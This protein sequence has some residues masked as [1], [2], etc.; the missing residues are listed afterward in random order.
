MKRRTF[1]RNSTAAGLALGM[2]VFPNFLSPL[3]EQRF[4]VAEAGYYMRWY[5]D[6]KSEVYPPFANALDMID[7]CHS[8][9]FGGVQ[10]NVRDWDK[11]MVRAVRDRQDS[12]GMFVEGQVRLPREES[13]LARFE[14]EITTARD[15]GV[16]I[17]RSVCLSGRRY[18]T[19][20]SLEAFNTFREESIA[21]IRR[22]E[23]V[24]RKQRVKLALENHKDW[25]F[26][27]MIEVLKQI[28]SEWV[29]VTLD[30]GNNIALL[31][32]PM[33]VV[34]ALAP[35][36]FSVHLKDM[37]VEEYADGFLLS[38][39]NLGEGYLD[40]PEMIRIIREHNAEARFNL[41]MITRDPL[42]IPCL[43][44]AYWATFAPRPAREL[45]AY[46]HS[47]RQ[48]KRQP[49]TLARIS[50]QPTDVQLALEVENNRSCLLHAKKQ[51]GFM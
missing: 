15:A 11:G 2:P 19:F 34:T 22:A 13:D 23:P 33:E 50:G 20:D 7:H 1:V 45:A 9:G 8:L 37:G 4:G 16:T 44:E 41:E 26:D 51:Y 35:Y 38:E 32:D 21:A 43:T 5:G 24:C 39:V 3:A 18:E 49:Q 31:E 17:F 6:L 48:H 46:L 14:K 29:G 25:Q 42:E 12:L 28:D 47:I 40:I 30:T 10:V 27:E 36:T